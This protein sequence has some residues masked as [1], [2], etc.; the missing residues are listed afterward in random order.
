MEKCPFCNIRQG[1][2]MFET[3]LSVCISDQFPVSPGHA[4]VVPKRHVASYF[5]LNYEEIKDL[6]LAVNRAKENLDH[7]YQPDGYNIGINIGKTAG[8]TVPHVHIHVI[9]RYNGDVEDPR[10]GIRG[11]IPEK[12]LY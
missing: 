5:D 1:E 12:K 9:P 10:G 8:Q 11:V 4:L 6:W 2:W 3:E 7:L